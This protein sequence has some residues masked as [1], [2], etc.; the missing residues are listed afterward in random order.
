MKQVKAGHKTELVRALGKP[1]AQSKIQLECL[2]VAIRR[3]ILRD[4]RLELRGFGTFKI[5]KRNARRAQN[6]RTG[7]TVD[8]LERSTVKF[9]PGKHFL[10]TS[11]SGAS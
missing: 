6:P 3:I 2:L 7:G 10:T 4:G 8:I 11:P 9:K 1:Y 5:V